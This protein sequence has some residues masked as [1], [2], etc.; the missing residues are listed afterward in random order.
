M[1]MI[2][3]LY[4]WSEICTSRLLSVGVQIQQC[5]QTVTRDWGQNLHWY[6]GMPIGLLG[7]RDFPRFNWDLEAYLWDSLCQ[8]VPIG[9]LTLKGFPSL[10]KYFFFTIKP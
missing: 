4:W 6:Q 7:P 10:K 8:M 3:W 5:L 2:T 1:A 9:L